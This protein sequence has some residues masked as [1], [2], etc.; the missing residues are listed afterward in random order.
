MAG[1][2]ENVTE[3]VPV[4]KYTKLAKPNDSVRGTII[5]IGDGT[6]GPEVLFQLSKG[7]TTMTCSNAQLAAWVEQTAQEGEEWEITLL[8]QDEGRDGRKGM[9]HFRF[10][11]YH[12]SPAAPTREEVNPEDSEAPADE[13]ESDVSPF[14]E[15]LAR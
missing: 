9:K 6:Y 7:T 2:T 8:R 13:S 1:N 3:Y 12:A 5:K 10:R 11:Q 14:T 15:A 4:S